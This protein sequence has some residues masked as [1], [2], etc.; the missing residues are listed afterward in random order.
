M[1]Q[2]VVRFLTDRIRHRLVVKVDGEMTFDVAVNYREEFL[3]RINEIDPTEYTLVLDCLKQKPVSIDVINIFKG[4]MIL[5]K[6]VPFK[7]R[8]A[9]IMES[10][11]ARRQIMALGKEKYV[12]EFKWLNTMQE[13]EEQLSRG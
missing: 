8:Y 10:P 4:V 9:V 3:R 6:E 1:A 13:V 2:Q 5:Y 7:D 11:V 12:K